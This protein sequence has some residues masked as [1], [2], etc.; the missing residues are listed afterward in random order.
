[1]YP[2]GFFPFIGVQIE[3]LVWFYIFP[4]IVPQLKKKGTQNKIIDTVSVLKLSR[5]WCMKFMI[6]M[7]KNKTALREVVHLDRWDNTSF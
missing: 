3:G 5:V 4:V 6:R 1:M 7:V 2:M